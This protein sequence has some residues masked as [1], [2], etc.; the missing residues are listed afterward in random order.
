MMPA[1][2]HIGCCPDDAEPGAFAR[3]LL[4][5]LAEE[6][7]GIPGFTPRSDVMGRPLPEDGIS[8]S[9]SHD[10]LCVA[11]ALAHSAIG[12]DIEIPRERDVTLLSMFPRGEWQLLGGKTWRNFYRL[13][14]A[15]EA[16]IKCMGATLDAL[17]DVHLVDAL[18]TTLR[19]RYALREFAVQSRV[20][21]AYVCSCACFT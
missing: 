17:L 16:C 12:I 6:R 5:D 20:T 21:D 1:V 13:W 4:G 10:E 11:V 3:S 8:W 14:T 19:L 15:K 9:I 18:G 2:I 7:W